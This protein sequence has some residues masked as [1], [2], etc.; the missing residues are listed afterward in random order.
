MAGQN[1]VAAQFEEFDWGVAANPDH[2]LGT[3]LWLMARDDRRFD[4]GLLVGAQVKTSKTKSATSKY[5]KQPQRDEQGKVVGWWY[6]ESLRDDHFDYWIKHSVPHIV[7]LHDLQ[8]GNSYWEHV[9]RKRIVRTKSGTKILVPKA[10]RINRAHTDRLLDVA[11][12]QRGIRGRWEGSDWSDIATLG[13]DELARYATLTPRLIANRRKQRTSRDEN[14]CEA[15]AM[16]V[17][18]RLTEL[19]GTRDLAAQV[20]GI[21]PPPFLSAEEA[22]ASGQWE[23]NLYGTLHHYLHSGDPERFRPLV[24]AAPLNSAQRATAVV[25]YSAMLIECGRIAEALALT[26]EELACALKLDPVN[27]AWIEVQHARCLLEVGRY[28]KARKMA[29]HVQQIQ[30]AAAADPT[31]MAIAA[32]ASGILFRA[33]GWFPRHDSGFVSGNDTAA[34]WWRNQTIALGLERFLNDRFTLWASESS[35]RPDHFNDTWQA[36]RTATLLSGFAGD[37]VA[38]RAEYAQLARYTLQAFPASQLR[39]EAYEGCLTNLRLAGDADGVELCVKKL[40]LAGPEDAVRRACASVRLWDSTHTTGLS[41]LKF[42]AAAAEVLEQAMADTYVRELVD[43]LVH[44]SR[45]EKR[46]RPTFVI[47]V[48]VFETLEA[49]IRRAAVS[50]DG[51]RAVIHYFLSLPPVTDASWAHSLTRLLRAIP[52]SAWT[53]EDLAE[54]R[55][56]TNDNWDL[57]DTVIG[58]TAAI[59]DEADAEL[60]DSLRQ[61]DVRNLSSVRDIRALPSEVAAAQIDSL[62]ASVNQEVVDA[63]AGTFYRNHARS[64]AM[65]NIWHPEVSNWTPIYELLNERRVIPGSVIDI[66]CLIRDASTHIAPEISEELLP[67]LEHVRDRPPIDF[68]EWLNASTTLRTVVREAID[69][70]A[71]GRVSDAELWEL[72]G[73]DSEQRSAAARIVGRRQDVSRLDVLACLSHDE[74]SVVR[75]SAARWIAKWLENSEVSDRCNALLTV[76][77]TAPGTVIARAIGMGLQSDASRAAAGDWVA[78]LPGAIDHGDG[79]DGD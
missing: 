35:G 46:V 16:L 64:L 40:L 56:R 62:A 41:D 39:D 53:A 44:Q 58:I 31:A 71:P 69:A 34:G 36:L 55:L 78:T 37:H 59:G 70:L 68:G 32:S 3:D 61:G 2:D 48:Y 38:W 54:L 51:R 11:V 8:S 60:L 12:S 63:R 26:R 74:S 43:I 27:F 20:P 66:A 19:D 1:R 4:L 76:L 17:Q 29:I 21:E 22:C 24:E 73:G 14:P 50:S 25:V 75:A 79:G 6:W 30:S 28:K 49:L 33:S 52:D 5:F 57:K 18:G 72:I 67:W 47:H 15:I 10:Q 77:A 13:L 65:F 7:V 42:V 45:Y 23:W 9:T